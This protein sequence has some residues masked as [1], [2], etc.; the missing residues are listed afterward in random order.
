MLVYYIGKNEQI[1]IEMF[2]HSPY[3]EIRENPAKLDR[4]DY[5][6]T[7]FRNIA[8]EISETYDESQK[9]KK[10]K[11]RLDIH[12]ME[13]ELTRMGYSIQKNAITE[14]VVISSDRG[15]CELSFDDLS[16]LLYSEIGGQY[17]D[18]SQST[19]QNYLELIA[20]QHKFN[21]VF[22]YLNT[23]TWD[24]NDHVAE[25]YKLMGI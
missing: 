24:G 19:I 9:R 5:M 21:P 17:I 20:K 18:R 10:G 23:L 1:C 16:I 2:R 22:D 7:T 25:L 8:E 13:Q 11:T 12:F 14:E 4:D 3:A 6:A 15:D